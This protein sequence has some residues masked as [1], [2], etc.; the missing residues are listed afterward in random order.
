MIVAFAADCIVEAGAVDATAAV[1]VQGGQDLDL[2]LWLR[3]G[4]ED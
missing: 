2:R 4:G 1:I 3:R